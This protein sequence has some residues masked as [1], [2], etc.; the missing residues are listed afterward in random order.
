MNGST[1]NYLVAQMSDLIDQ[2]SAEQHDLARRLAALRRARAEL[3]FGRSPGVVLALLEEEIGD[4]LETLVQGRQGGRMF[5]VETGH[6]SEKPPLMNG[7][8]ISLALGRSGN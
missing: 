3:R 6:A 1:R 4:P 5:A 2:Y 8:C 7:V